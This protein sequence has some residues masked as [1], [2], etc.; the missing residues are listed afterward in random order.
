MIGNFW[1]NS[2]AGPCDSNLISFSS[3]NDMGLYLL[4]YGAGNVQS[5][6]NS[7]IKLGHSFK[8]VTEAEDFHRA[9]VS[10]CDLA[11]HIIRL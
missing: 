10:L 6:A 3:D 2:G 7:I 1:L 11:S 4:D 5:L 9:T 8:W